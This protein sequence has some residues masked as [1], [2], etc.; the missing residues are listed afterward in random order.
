MDR[1][2]RG[3]VAK[4]GGRRDGRE[5]EA[6]VNFR[7]GGRERSLFFFFFLCVRQKLSGRTKSAEN[8]VCPGR[9]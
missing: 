4:G 5:R 2:W 6:G 9:H 1:R 3:P 8:G 7:V